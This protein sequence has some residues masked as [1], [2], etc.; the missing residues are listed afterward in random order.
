MWFKLAFGS[1]FLFALT[2]A[3]R[4]S[5]LAARHHGGSL[6]H[7]SHEVRGLLILRAALGI[8]FY[9]ALAAWMFWPRSRCHCT[10]CLAIVE[11]RTLGRCPLR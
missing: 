11:A 7:L 5:R 3:A 6:S 1:S 10:G 8:I 2:V 4:T 9:T